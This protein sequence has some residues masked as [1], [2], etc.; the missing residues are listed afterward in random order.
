M[1]VSP[2]LI[3]TSSGDIR[4][5]PC[6]NCIDCCNKKATRNNLLCICE[7]EHYKYTMFVTLTYDRHSVPVARL[8][9][10]ED[11]FQ[12]RNLTQRLDGLFEDNIIWTGV[13]PK[14]DLL[15]LNTLFNENRF[16]YFKRGEIP[17]SCSY[18]VQC[19]IKRLRYYI[20]QAEYIPE[21]EKKIRYFAA[22]EYGPKSFRPHF[23]ILVYTNSTALQCIL[24]HFVHKA[25]S[26]GRCDVQL[27]RGD[28]G[29]Y[30]AQYTTGNT[31]IPA[32]HKM[33][34]SIRPRCCHSKEFGL[35]KTDELSK[36]EPLL[37]Y[38]ALNQR[39]VQS[40]TKLLPIASS[41]SL[42]SALFPKSFAYSDTND[43]RRLQCYCLLSEAK[44]I[45]G[46]GYTFR[47][48]SRFFY[49]YKDCSEYLPAQVRWIY[50][51][52]AKDKKHP[53]N[54]NTFYSILCVSSRFLHLC[55]LLRLSPTEYLSLINKY[56]R[57]KKKEVLHNWYKNREQETFSSDQVIYDYDNLDDGSHLRSQK[58]K[59]YKSCGVN[60]SS[61]LTNVNSVKNLCN[62]LGIS[63]P[64][65]FHRYGKINDLK[66]NRKLAAAYCKAQTIRD[67]R[68]KHKELQD[69][70]SFLDY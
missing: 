22:L 27:S 36:K 68:L 21:G 5:V 29:Q 34:G 11:G 57:D 59:S 13:L 39:Y 46:H 24:D 10:C 44:Q 58:E 32:V 42:E 37:Y 38:S 28:A 1:C 15:N 18:D 54:E 70:N 16:K 50:E 67:Y 49:F 56:Y 64:T 60:M 12:L 69:A 20:E 66:H 55:K 8:E 40:G 62:D 30:T 53:L 3:K 9:R 17:F 61:P 43:I 45:F 35:R 23:H 14:K 26:F 6:N 19:F 48:Y 25:W 51:E 65:L 52:K 2:V 7:G 4:R 47:E 63:L 31:L 33:A 41:I